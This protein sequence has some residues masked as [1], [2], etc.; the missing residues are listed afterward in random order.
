MQNVQLVWECSQ[1]LQGNLHSLQC[2]IGLYKDVYPL[3][4]AYRQLLFF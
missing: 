3:G 4:H 1:F 2:F